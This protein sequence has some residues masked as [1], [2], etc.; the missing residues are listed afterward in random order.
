[1]KVRRE[2]LTDA[3]FAAAM[4]ATPDEPSRDLL[5][6]LR[7]TGCRP[8][9]AF[10]LTAGD[11][12]LDLGVWSVDHKT[13]SATGR[14]RTVPLSP[15]AAE[16]TA[17]WLTRTPAGPI[18]GNTRGNHWT[19]HA[20]AIRWAKLRKKLGYGPEAT[21]YAI[22]HRSAREGL[23][24]GASYAD[25]AALLGHTSTEMVDRVYSHVNESAKYLRDALGRARSEGDHAGRVQG[26]RR[27]GTA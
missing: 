14:L 9:E 3:Q 13:R 4:A 18:F 12:F 6:V 23:I 2:V 22:R 26:D 21:G 16:L 1:M 8:G 19:R 5:A 20:V 11:V 7:G 17:N 25:M 10:G 24:N 27:Q 15:R